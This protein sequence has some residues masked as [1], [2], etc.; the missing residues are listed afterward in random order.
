MYF[1]R[2]K[3]CFEYRVTAVIPYKKTNFLFQRKKKKYL[4]VWSVRNHHREEELTHQAMAE[5]VVIIFTHGVR[6]S[7]RHK[8]KVRTTTDIMRK[9]VKII[10]TH[11][12]GPGGSSEIR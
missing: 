2:R 4:E 9:I 6:T 11:W 1:F 10:T 7:V 12:M 8:H 3:V 5:K